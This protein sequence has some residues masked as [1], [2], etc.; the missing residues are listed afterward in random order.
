MISRELEKEGVPIAHITAMTI[1]SKQIGAN[2]VITGTKIPHPCGDPNMS[3]ED[4]KDL[5]RAIVECAFEALQR[6][7]EEPTIFVPDVTFTSG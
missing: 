1:L 6:D 3:P 5:R 2:R 7:V 4:D